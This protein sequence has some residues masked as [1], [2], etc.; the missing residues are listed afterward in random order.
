[1]IDDPNAHAPPSPEALANWNAAREISA[2]HQIAVAEAEK[3][4]EKATKLATSEEAIRKRKEREEKR[5]AAARAKALAEGLPIDE[6]PVPSPVS[7]LVEDRPATPSKAAAHTFN[8]TVPA[9]SSELE[10]YTPNT[11]AYTTLE[12]ARE[13]GIWSYP[14]TSYERAKCRV[15][16]DLWEK[17]NFMG[18]GI[19]FGG[20]FLVYPGMLQ[21][22]IHVDN[23]LTSLQVTRCVITRT[24]SLR[25]SSLLRQR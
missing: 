3:Q 6:A 12:A 19:K 5:A 14:A 8:V 2:R 15:Y 22:R 7:A 18:G 9:S 20:D 24:L 25:L 16:Q 21:V 1:M 23:L 10:W 11:L 13:A 17:G 4:S